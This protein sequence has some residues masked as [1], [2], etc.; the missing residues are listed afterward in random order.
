[1]LDKLILSE[2]RLA[3]KSLKEL[4]RNH[5]CEIGK[6]VNGTYKTYAEISESRDALEGAIWEAMWLTEVITQQDKGIE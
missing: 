3:F 4:L 2:K 6:Y 1:M 5:E